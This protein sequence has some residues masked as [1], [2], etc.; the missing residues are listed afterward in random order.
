MVK[1]KNNDF[2]SDWSN[3]ISNMK[4][5][6]KRYF[7][8]TDTER[9]TPYQFDGINHDFDSGKRYVIFHSNENDEYYVLE[10]N[11]FVDLFE[12]VEVEY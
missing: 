3:S 6:V 7:L 9:L 1:K 12:E 5:K 10:F 8:K 2:V 4:M 11:R